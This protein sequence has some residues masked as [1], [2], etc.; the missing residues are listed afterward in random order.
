MR[1]LNS[2]GSTFA[3]F[4]KF[5]VPL[6]IVGLVTPAIASAGRT[7]GRL[8]SATLAI[9]W[10]STVLSGFFAFGIARAVL[11]RIV[12][13]L[14]AASGAANTFPAYFTLEITP[15][16]DVVSATALAFVFGL[17]MA[18]M[19]S[20][21]LMRAFGEVK[22]VVSRTIRKAVVPLLPFYIFAVVANLTACGHLAQICGPCL[23]ITGVAL[24]T[25]W[26]VL[27]LEYAVAGAVGRK[28]PVKALWTML[29]AYFTGFGCCSSAAT[30]PV[31]LR[32][33]KA[34]GV[35]DE[36][37]NLVVPLCANIHL[38]GSTAK[39]VVFSAG[40]LIASGGAIHPGAFAEYILLLSILAVAAPGVP[41]GMVLAAAPVAEST[42]GLAPDI[43]AI[44]MA[45]YLAVNGIGTAANLTGDGAIALIIDKFKK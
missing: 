28:N 39:I 35:S 38:A 6:I 5:I 12:S 19:D 2:F 34:N 15:V 45:A 21:A 8:L 10:V 36:T 31:T 13:G 25:T 26:L 9:A 14:P 17:A 43:Y 20:P 32:Q 22:A 37:A 1:A 7:A 18:S 29:P 3:W 40:F 23:K 30:I 11:P 41:G 24:A 16:M 44:L 27:A 4:V 33:V 42:I